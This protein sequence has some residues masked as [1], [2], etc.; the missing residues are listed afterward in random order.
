M[1]FYLF[2]SEKRA[3][4]AIMQMARKRSRYHFIR[5]ISSLISVVFSKVIVKGVLEVSSKVL[6]F[7]RNSINE[8]VCDEWFFGKLS[9]TSSKKGCLLLESLENFSSSHFYFKLPC[10]HLVS[11]GESRLL[12]TFWLLM[13][14]LSVITHLR[15][16]V[17]NLVETFQ[18]SGCSR[19]ISEKHII[20]TS[21]NIVALEIMCLDVFFHD[22][23][24]LN[25]F[26][27]LEEIEGL[28]IVCLKANFI[29]SFRLGP[30][31][32]AV[33]CFIPLVSFYT[34]W[35]H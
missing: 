23:C 17:D 35:K 4:S 5:K 24:L 18:R 15:V 2:V 22:I 7:L 34:S 27:V 20:F 9:E 16:E 6:K 13:M 3:N 28:D 25:F 8:S 21:T 10:L 29:F 26:Q 33:T 19:I 31:V 11:C 32:F 12:C 30:L 1:R 14:G